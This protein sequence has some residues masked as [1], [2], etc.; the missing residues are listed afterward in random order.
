MN[1]NKQDKKKTTSPSKKTLAT[2]AETKETPEQ[3]EETKSQDSITLTQKPRAIEPKDD[4]DDLLNHKMDGLS[5]TQEKSQVVEEKIIV[6]EKVVVEEKIVVDDE[7]KKRKRSEETEKPKKVPKVGDSKDELK[8]K[9]IT[10][11]KKLDPRVYKFPIKLAETNCH[12]KFSVGHDPKHYEMWDECVKEKMF[13]V[14]EGTQRTEV[15]IRCDDVGRSVKTITHMIENTFNSYDPT[16]FLNE[17]WLVDCYDAKKVV[18]IEEDHIHIPMS[19]LYLKFT[20]R[21]T[22]TRKFDA[23]VCTTVG[24]STIDENRQLFSALFDKRGVT[25]NM[26]VLNYLGEKELKTKTFEKGEKTLALKEPKRTIIYISSYDKPETSG[27]GRY[28]N[29][30]YMGLKQY[31]KGLLDEVENKKT[32]KK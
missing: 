28:N 5:S 17:K 24:F 31:L 22:R 27:G 20:A 10:D 6:E 15:V 13:H 21:L 23:I 9:V 8:A 7:E 25:S 3:Q 29:L 11:L 16:F 18:P 30:V 4:A 1:G 14:P 26:W 12:A 19:D 2:K 32:S